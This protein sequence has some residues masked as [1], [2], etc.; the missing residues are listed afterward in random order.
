MGAESSISVTS[1][2]KELRFKW[3]PSSVD[4]PEDKLRFKI[5]LGLNKID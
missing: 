2:K 5:R 3:M 1:A 4:N